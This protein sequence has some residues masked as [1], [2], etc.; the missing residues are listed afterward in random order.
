MVTVDGLPM[1][2]A[3]DEVLSTTRC[4]RKGLDTTREVPRESCR[5][6][7]ARGDARARWVEWAV[8]PLHGGDRPGQAGCCRRVLQAGVGRVP[9]AAVLGGQPAFRRPGP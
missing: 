4:V 6:L 7:P 3:V 5:G 1:Q 8:S 9:A 2:S